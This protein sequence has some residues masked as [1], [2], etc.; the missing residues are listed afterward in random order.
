MDAWEICAAKS[1]VRERAVEALDDKDDP[2]TDPEGE[3]DVWAL[4][5][6]LT[7]S[8]PLGIGEV[9]RDDV[10]IESGAFPAIPLSSGAV[11]GQ[12]TPLLSWPFTG[13]G[14]M[15][16]Y[17]NGHDPSRAASGRRPE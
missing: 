4:A 5:L 14:T 3:E 16:C 7:E 11:S 12:T 8:E 1:P 17:M 10:G 9:T 6:Y 15:P 13:A 2:S